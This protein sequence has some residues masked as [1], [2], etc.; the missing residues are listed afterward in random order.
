[1]ARSCLTRLLCPVPASLP[2]PPNPEPPE[3]PR[4][5]PRLVCYCILLSDPPSAEAAASVTP[6]LI[7]LY[8]HHPTLFPP[9]TMV[10]EHGARLVGP[11]T[12]G[13]SGEILSCFVP[14]LNH[15]KLPLASRG[16]RHG[17]HIGGQ[18]AG[19]GRRVA[20]SELGR[21]G[22]SRWLPRIPTFSSIILISPHSLTQ[23]PRFS[24][25]QM[26][27]VVWVASAR[28][29]RSSQLVALA[30]LGDLGPTDLGAHSC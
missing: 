28:L 26:S 22:E 24:G 6:S 16:L 11:C 13:A 21:R 23:V 10:L 8:I 25:T 3:E 18:G 19:R 9:R 17:G 2:P 30:Y 14:P 12:C 29:T 27:R 20:A 7:V 4:T 1:M 5:R 15:E